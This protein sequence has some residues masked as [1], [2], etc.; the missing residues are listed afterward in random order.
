MEK[1]DAA[2]RLLEIR[3]LRKELEKEESALKDMFKNDG[4][5]SFEAQNIM[6]LVTE[7]FRENLD[8][9]GLET[10][11]GSETIQGFVKKTSYLQVDLK[12]IS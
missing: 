12:V 9:K 8:R 1:L 3:N 10:T 4:V 5:G 6:V 2:K 7:K 11:F